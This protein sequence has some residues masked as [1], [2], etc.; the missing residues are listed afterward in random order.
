MSDLNRLSAES[1]AKPLVGIGR[2]VDREWLEAAVGTI[3]DSLPL[4]AE[5][6]PRQ[7]PSVT[8]I[9]PSEL[10]ELG[11]AS[12]D[13][14]CVAEQARLFLASLAIDTQTPSLPSIGQPARTIRT[15][16]NIKPV[17]T[18]HRLQMRLLDKITEQY[19]CGYL[20]E[21]EKIALRSL[22]G[23]EGTHRINK[24]RAPRPWLKLG[25]IT[26]IDSR[27]KHAIT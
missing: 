20:I 13:A 4:G 17:N 5:F 26:G 19:D 18:Q 23:L 11:G 10:A 1:L 15:S 7:N 14:E 6:Y 2:P 3:Q 9:N 8:Y 25:I 21:G 27:E 22:L 12:A 24:D 16:M